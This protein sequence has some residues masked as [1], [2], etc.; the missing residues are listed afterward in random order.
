V[1]LGVIRSVPGHTYEND[2]VEQIKGVQKSAKI[3]CMDDLLLS[4]STWKVE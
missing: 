3:K 2:V 1:A 4:G